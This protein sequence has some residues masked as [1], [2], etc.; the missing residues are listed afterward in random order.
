MTV[1]MKAQSQFSEKRQTIETLSPEQT[2]TL[3]EKIGAKLKPGDLVLLYGSL[4][5]GKTVLTKGI[6]KAFNI[7]FARSP[8]FVYINVYAGIIPVYH[9]DL[10][11]VD[12]N[13]IGLW[14]EIA[15]YL[16]DED[17]IKIVEWG[18]KLPEELLPKNVVRIFLEIKSERERTISIEYL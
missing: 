16:Y 1:K 15:E 2:F 7:D 14:Q 17:A 10:Y 5:A 13:S 4:G 6:C 3:G 18:E 9:I 8:S 11:R 12:E